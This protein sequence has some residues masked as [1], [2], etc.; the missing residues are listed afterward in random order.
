MS[1][2]A[3][4]LVLTQHVA[5]RSR[6]ECAATRLCFPIAWM[7]AR[8][9]LTSPL[10][11]KRKPWSGILLYGPP[12]TGKSYLAKVR[13]PAPSSG[14]Q[15]EAHHSYL[16]TP[17]IVS[18]LSTACAI[19]LRNRCPLADRQISG[20]DLSLATH[21]AHVSSCCALVCTVKPPIRCA[22]LGTACPG[23]KPKTVPG[24]R[25]ASSAVARNRDFCCCVSWQL[26]MCWVLD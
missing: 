4:R 2:V 1:T 22:S 19:C 7:R 12:G 25:L 23:S 20:L 5:M 17:Y 16:L 9:A 13:L 10:A 3:A 14:V 11:G 26:H 8:Q 24:S 15:D 6:T 18:G 21:Q